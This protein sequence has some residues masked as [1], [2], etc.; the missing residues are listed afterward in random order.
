[1]TEPHWWEELSGMFK[2]DPVFD[3]MLEYGRYVRLTG[4]TPLDD[5]NPGDPIP[6][7]TAEEDE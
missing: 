6:I 1:M 5:W 2:D 3:E 7:P 4:Q